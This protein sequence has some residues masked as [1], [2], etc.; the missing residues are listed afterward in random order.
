MRRRNDLRLSQAPPY[1]KIEVVATL[2][3]MILAAVPTVLNLQ[4]LSIAQEQQQQSLSNQTTF[5]IEKP[6]EDLSSRMIT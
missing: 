2:T 4:Q 6:V 3:V 1:V 5:D